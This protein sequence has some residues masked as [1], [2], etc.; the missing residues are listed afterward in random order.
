MLGGINTRVFGGVFVAVVV[1]CAGIYFYTAWQDKRFM[2]EIG[3]PSV[4]TPAAGG[5]EKVSGPV[6]ADKAEKTLQE[7]EAVPHIA[8]VEFVEADA[9]A[10]V[11]GLD[12][13]VSEADT[14]GAAAEF[15][16]MPLISAFGLP[17]SVTDLLG[18]EG[19]AGDFEAARTELIESY[20]GSPEVEAIL[21]RLKE[22]SGRP[23]EIDA[24]IDLFEAWIEILPVEEQENR[25]GLI[26]VLTMLQEAKAVGGTDAEFRIEVHIDKDGVD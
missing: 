24:L 7:G 16:P 22:M 5:Q 9:I 1:L 6:A 4:A 2:A 10:P 13:A 8:P 20:G 12:D 17:E 25:R 19:E 26:G 11:E 3:K 15:D 23:V 18:E 14:T 21:E